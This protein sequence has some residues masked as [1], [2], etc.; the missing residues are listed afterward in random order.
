MTG[1]DLRLVLADYG[2]GLDTELALLSQLETL[3]DG[4]HAAT[5]SNDLAAVSRVADERDRTL[6]ALIEVEA[7]VRPLRGVLARHAAEARRLDAFAGVAER[8]RQATRVVASILARDGETLTAL[9]DAGRARRLAAQ[10][11]E[12]GEATLAA[13]RR[14]IAPPLASAGLVSR[15]I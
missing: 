4:Q 10:A 13:Y 3:A 12:A 6:Q 5:A 7:R 14:V 1:D 8:H 9:R 11:I 2:R 15:K